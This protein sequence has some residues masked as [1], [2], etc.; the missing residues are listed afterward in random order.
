MKNIAMIGVAHP[1]AREWAKAFRAHTEAELA[2]AWDENAGRKEQWTREEGGTAYDNLEDIL[3]DPCVDAVGICSETSRHAEY[4]IAAAKAGKDILC[5]KPA[6]VSIEECD[7]MQ[8]AIDESGVRYMQAFPMRIDPVNYRIKELIESGEIGNVMTF[9]K[10]H[11]IGWAA[12]PEIKEDLSWFTKE[13]HAG[14]GAFLDEGIHAADFLIW[15]FG[16]PKSVTAR[17]VKKSGNVPTDDNGIA[18][19][20][21]PDNIIGSLQSS[22]LFNAAFVTTEIFGSEGTIIQSYND[23]ASTAVNGEN[24]FPLQV[25][26]KKQNIRGWKSPRMPISF[27]EIHQQVAATFV[28][29]LVSGEEF[30]STLKNGRDA[31]NLILAAY[32]SASENKTIYFQEGFK[33]E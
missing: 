16:Q 31:L 28:D 12:S 24:N 8:K 11:G 19:V 21:F 30:P 7:R 13:E 26:S 14:G 6:A 2:G 4:V 15:M 9:R 25:Y 5:E 23:C 29:C 20:E 18:I 33:H 17:I 32:R 3:N 10:R 27:K 22:W 1:H